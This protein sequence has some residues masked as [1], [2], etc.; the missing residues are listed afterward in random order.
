VNFT[1]GRKAVVFDVGKIKLGDVICYE[2][3]F[4]DLVRS[5][6]NAGA[7]L[8]AVQSN[9]ADFEIDGQL[10]ETE[11]QTA[12]ARIRAIESDRAVVYASTTGRKLD[13]RAGRRADR[14]QRHLAAGDPG[15]PGAAG[16][17]PHAGGPGGSLAGVRDHRADR[18][19]ARLGGAAPAPQAHRDRTGA[20]TPE[21]WDP[22]DAGTPTG[23][24]P[25]L[26][27]RR[28]RGGH[29]DWDPGREGR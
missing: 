22:E 17:L 15:R 3:G 21:D 2:V 24:E 12:M 6:V 5:E 26:G 29:R 1:P 13:H 7:N 25:D 11:Q 27:G 9:D 23:L 14:A 8:L 28:D 20:G 19:R 18:A 10:G 4:D 16:Q